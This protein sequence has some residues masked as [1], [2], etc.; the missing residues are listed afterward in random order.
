[1][2]E[3]LALNLLNGQQGGEISPL[4]ANPVVTMAYVPVQQFQTMYE[5]E[6]ALCQGTLFPELNKPFTAYR[7]A[8]K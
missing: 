3:N 8:V 7:G 5:P 1:M 4:P 2:H 6:E